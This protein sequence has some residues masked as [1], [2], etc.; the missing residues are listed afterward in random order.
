MVHAS[1]CA[2]MPANRRQRR[3]GGIVTILA[4]LSLAALIGFAGL[5][6][7]LGRMY[8][9]KTELQNATDAC[10]L[11]AANELTCESG[12][13]TC[14]ENAESAGI[15][16]ARQNKTNFQT[17]DVAIA[18]EDIKF[19]TAIGPNTSYLSRAAGAPP[20]SR[21]AQCT[22]N[23]SGIVPWFM[24]VVG[25][26]ELSVS[27]MAV[28]TLAPGQTSC[29]AAPIGICASDPAAASFGFNA[30]D[31]VTGTFAQAPGNAINLTGNLRW[32]DFQSGAG[33]INA[34]RDQLLGNGAV[35]G[36]RTDAIVQ[37]KNE[38]DNAR[39]A[40]NTRFGIYTG[41]DSAASAA[42]DKTGYAYPSQ[43]PAATPVPLNASAY[44][45]YR[46]RQATH[47]P[48]TA[49]EYAPGSAG[50]SAPISAAVHLARGAERRLI[51]VPVIRCNG[52]TSVNILAMACALMLNPMSNGS[53]GTVY[54]EWRGLASNPASPCRSAGVAGAGGPLVTTLV[55]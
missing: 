4:A 52:A 25:I 7:D 33:G 16:A 50:I 30:G 42:P 12:V 11:A 35:C 45:D 39:K 31:W 15:F 5:V 48:F 18:T 27:A 19:H 10:A 34:I 6:L 54:L 1:N 47:T 36:I 2:C 37:T 41:T 3:E 29:N 38:A 51:A 43:V 17:S 49:D 22:A 14:L 8:V 24:G 55:Q 26:G 53:S 40:W 20:A 9:N 28:A 13:G 46:A 32:I 44:A 21:F 23:V